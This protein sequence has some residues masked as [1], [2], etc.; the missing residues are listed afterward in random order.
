MVNDVGKLDAY[1]H[2]TAIAGMGRRFKDPPDRRGHWAARSCSGGESKRCSLRRAASPKALF[3]LSSRGAAPRTVLCRH[4]QRR[5]RLA[6]RSQELPAFD[7]Q[8]CQPSRRDAEPWTH[9]RANSCNCSLS[10]HLERLKITQSLV[11]LGR[12]EEVVERGE[13]CGARAMRISAA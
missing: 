7:A 5:P 11:S 8:R 9:R 6:R 10:Q 1:C 2:P 13:D 4:R 3:L 12:C